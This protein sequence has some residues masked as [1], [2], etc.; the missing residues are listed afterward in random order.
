MK[1][2]RTLLV[3]TFTGLLNSGCIAY[4]MRDEL[5][6]INKQLELA[7]AA[8]SD[9]D[10]KLVQTQQTVATIHES[11]ESSDRSLKSI[12]ESMEPIRIS[13]RRVDD[14][15]AGMIQTIQKVDKFVPGKISPDTPPP[16][17]QEPTHETTPQ[18]K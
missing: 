13:L 2:V 12:N 14:E 16:A 9:M 10:H 18:N 11:M 5:R 7:N 1:T 8:L 4:E 17:K 15:L 6:T 3:L